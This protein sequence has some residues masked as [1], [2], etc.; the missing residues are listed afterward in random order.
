[1]ERDEKKI[2]LIDAQI[3]IVVNKQ[4]TEQVAWTTL[5]TG[6]LS[7]G[8]TKDEVEKL[9]DLHITKELGKELTKLRQQRNYYTKNK[10]YYQKYY[11]A[12]RDERRAKYHEKKKAAEKD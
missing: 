7:E 1:M 2:A 9:K 11:Q 10:A 6:L 12:H 8:W 5:K 3:E 4:T